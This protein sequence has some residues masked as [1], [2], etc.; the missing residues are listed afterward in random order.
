[1]FDDDWFQCSAQRVK[2]N[3]WFIRFEIRVITFVKF[4]QNNDVCL[5]KTM[6]IIFLFCVNAKKTQQC[7]H[8]FVYQQLKNSVWYDM[9]YN[10]ETLS[11]LHFLIVWE[12]SFSIIFSCVFATTFEY[13]YFSVS[14]KSICSMLEKNCLNSISTLSSN[15]IAF[16][17]IASFDLF[18]IKFEILIIFFDRWLLFCAQQARRQRNVVWLINVSKIFFNFK[19]FF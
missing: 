10:F 18:C 5:S 8:K 11:N 4:F 12:I 1:M 17:M 7:Q 19:Y 13:R 15:S 16:F 14:F 6:K 9:S 2:K 3:Y